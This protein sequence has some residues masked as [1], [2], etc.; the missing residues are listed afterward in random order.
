MKE[1]I[2]DKQNNLKTI[3]NTLSFYWVNP[4]LLNAWYV[5]YSTLQGCSGLHLLDKIERVNSDRW[6]EHYKGREIY[7][8]VAFV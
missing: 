1:E 5:P 8:V 3:F 6:D 2:F 7:G 4:S